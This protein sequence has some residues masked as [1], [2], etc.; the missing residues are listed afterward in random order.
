VN[1][2][3]FTDLM[4]VYIKNGYKWAESN[5]ELAENESVQQ[6]WKFFERRQHRRRAAFRLDID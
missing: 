6:Q 4:P 5:P 2:L 1:A 3:L